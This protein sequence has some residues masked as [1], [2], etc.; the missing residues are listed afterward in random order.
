MQ[1]LICPGYHSSDLTDDFLRCLKQHVSPTRLWVVPVW[2]TLGALPWLLQTHEPPD[3]NQP[4]QIIAFSAG[5]VAAYPLVLAWQH[6]GGQVQLL[7]LDGWGMPLLGAEK[8]Y[9][10]SHDRWTHTTTYWPSPQESAGYFYAEP[11]VDHLFLWQSPQATLGIG[12]VGGSSQVMT[13][14]EFIA[15]VLTG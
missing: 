6:M 4:L 2:Q 14:L 13:A 11:A 3:P 9:R 12:D 5:V 1:L 7:A 8:V 15:M 10:I